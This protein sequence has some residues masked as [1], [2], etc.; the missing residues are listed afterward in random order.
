MAIEKYNSSF[1]HGCNDLN[2]RTGEQHF[3]MVNFAVASHC[4]AI[5]G[6]LS[7]PQFGVSLEANSYLIKRRPQC[8]RFWKNTKL[9]DKIW[10]SC[11]IRSQGYQPHRYLPPLKCSLD[12]GLNNLVAKVPQ[13][14]RSIKSGILEIRPLES[15]DVS[16]SASLLTRVFLNAPESISGKNANAADRAFCQRA[17]VA[18]PLAIMLVAVLTPNDPSELGPG[19]STRLVGLAYVSLSPDSRPVF[20]NAQPPSSAAYLSSMAVDEKYRRQGIAKMLIEVCEGLCS[21]LNVKQLTL[22]AWSNDPVAQNCYQSCNFNFVKNKN[23][24]FLPIWK[25]NKTRLLMQKYLS[26]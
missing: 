5:R 18:P 10:S 12:S 24:T 26:S 7:R 4:Y 23:S 19:R 9:Q 3:P 13:N 16:D 22:H 15:Q 8:L 25:S 1:L 14:T 2:C 20:P 21:A 11:F 6:L 17:L